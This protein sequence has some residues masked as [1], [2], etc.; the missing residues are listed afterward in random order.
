M[1][2]TKRPKKLRPGEREILKALADS[3]KSYSDIAK[4]LKWTYKNGEGKTKIQNPTLLSDYLKRLQKLGLV[5]RDIDSRRYSAEKISIEKLFYNDVSNFL[6]EEVARDLEPKTPEERTV[7]PY[8]L[9]FTVTE[10]NCAEDFKNKIKELLNQPET[11]S[12]L[13]QFLHKMNALWEKTVLLQRGEKEHKIIIRYKQ[14]LLE[15]YKLVCKTPSLQDY[16]DLFSLTAEE[17]LRRDYPGIKNIPKEFVIIETERQIQILKSIDDCFNQ[18]QDLADLEKRLNH[19]ETQGKIKKDFSEE[20]KEKIEKI[21]EFLENKNN[22]KIYEGFLKSWN[23]D[24]K[25]LF[26]LPLLGFRGYRDK[27]KE[28]YPENFHEIEN[29]YLKK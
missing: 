18:P 10:H 26:V 23:N 19:A 6:K 20:E 4:T 2:K 1:S 11:I 7:I 29:R 8:S 22:K 14:E 9:W 16:A 5:S 17:K 13:N 25:V 24:P 28:L 21:A 3:P 15:A 12:A 27:L